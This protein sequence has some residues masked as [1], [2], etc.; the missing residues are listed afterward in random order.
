[1]TSRYLTEWALQSFRHWVTES[2]L[3]VLASIGF[4]HR[5]LSLHGLTVI[6]GGLTAAPLP[7]RSWNKE[8]WFDHR[9]HDLG[10][11]GHYRGGA[12]G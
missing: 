12:G 11:P 1:M 2:H 5:P 6:E 7:L 9:V 3:G 10:S 4:E 8:F